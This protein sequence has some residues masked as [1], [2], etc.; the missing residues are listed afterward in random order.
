MT[1]GLEMKFAASILLRSTHPEEPE[2]GTLWEE[3]IHIFEASSEADALTKATE[4]GR[5]EELSYIASA[6]NQVAWTL[7]K[8]LKACCIDSSQVDATEVFSRFLDNEQASA[9]L[10]KPDL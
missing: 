5:R 1:N 10:K 6:G 3:Q 7:V 9:L 8:V 2:G 4:I